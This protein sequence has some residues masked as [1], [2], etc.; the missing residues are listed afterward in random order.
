V[1]FNAGLVEHLVLVGDAS[2][3]EGRG[4]NIRA[5]LV[6]VDGLIGLARSSRSYTLRLP[7]KDAPVI[8][9]M[10]SLSAVY[11]SYGYRRI[12][13]FLRH[14]GLGLSWSRSHRKRAVIPPLKAR[15]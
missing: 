2:G 11:P 6:R 5:R 4:L 8:A 14:Q 10:K 13:M 9:A 7:T 15:A 12:R 1:Q 3:L